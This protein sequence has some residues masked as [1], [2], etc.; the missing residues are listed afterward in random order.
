MRAWLVDTAEVESLEQLVARSTREIEACTS[1]IGLH[2]ANR[3]FI[4]QT[5]QLIGA[6]RLWAESRSQSDNTIG[7]MLKNLDISALRDAA[8]R[9][10]EMATADAKAAS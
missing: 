2:L 1:E 6:L 8:Y 5:A 10:R 9:L 7:E 3:Y 4:D